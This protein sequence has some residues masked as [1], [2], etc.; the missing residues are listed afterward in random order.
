MFVNLARALFKL[1][2]HILFYL[3]G[4]LSRKKKCVHYFLIVEVRIRNDIDI[5]KIIFIIT[6]QIPNIGVRLAVLIYPDQWDFLN[7]D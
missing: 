6:S 2:L 7:K 4:D 3:F 5:D 1:P